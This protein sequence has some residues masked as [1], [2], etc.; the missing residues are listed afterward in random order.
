MK[1]L[2]WYAESFSPVGNI[3]S[4]GVQRQLG[5]Y[6]L[7]SLAVL[8]RETVQNSWDAHL[9]D[10]TPSYTLRGWILSDAQRATLR[11]A[12][13][14]NPNGLNLNLI[15]RN[16]P[17]AALAI[18]DRGTSGLMGPVRADEVTPDSQ[19]R[20]FVDFLLNIGQ[21][22]NTDFG[23]GTYGYGK[24]ILYRLSQVG[25]ILVHTHTTLNG[26]RVRRFM[27]AALGDQYEGHTGRHWWGQLSSDGYPE[28]VEGQ[29]ADDLAQCLGMPPFAYDETGTTVMIVDP[30][31]GTSYEDQVRG[32]E[33]DEPQPR[34]LEE[35]LAY[36][37][38]AILWNFWPK[39][40]TACPEDSRMIFTVEH[41]EEPL[42]IPS[43][44]WHPLFRLLT[45]TMRDVETARVDESHR[46]REPNRQVHEISTERPRQSVGLLALRRGPD[47][48]PLQY[49]PEPPSSNEE[50]IEQQIR[51]LSPSE[52]GQLHHVV[53]MRDARLIVRYEEEP[54]PDEG[55]YAGVFLVHRNE[56]VDD[57]FAEAEPPTH[58]NWEPTGMGRPEGTYVRKALKRIRELSTLFAY[59]ERDWK[60]NATPVA[61]GRLSSRL[62]GL[63]PAVTGTDPSV[64]PSMAH[65]SNT[66]PSKRTRNK[67]PSITFVDHQPNLEMHDGERVARLR[68]RVKAPAGLE[69]ALIRGHAAAL[70]I[71]GTALE[72][73]PPADAEQPAVLFWENNEGKTVGN[74][75]I[76][77]VVPD[78]DVIW[79]L[80]V[81][82]PGDAAV[83]MDITAEEAG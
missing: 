80:L 3:T 79:S 6:E 48:A 60:N 51:A 36:I 22:R 58:D 74:D 81:S 71:D 26:N 10:N 77:E 64:Q 4:E 37:S 15:D 66:R 52:N 59:H 2:D 50:R 56:A 69:L 76:I 43:P 27:G 8:V 18:A 34:S 44:D 1:V 38:A 40:I 67:R 20:D 23:G 30:A 62:A 13:H 53:L 72:D 73:A 5:R 63:V 14:G 17:V 57:A 21:N 83:S 32:D 68:F 9:A 35:A 24:S 82:I 42:P 55:Q 65:H 39:M 16:T 25:T 19:E 29:E 45:Q 46:P 11:G 49:L 75:E 12:L 7:D 70:V 33:V 28:P 61:L 41:G 78:P 54:Q 31:L 47:Q